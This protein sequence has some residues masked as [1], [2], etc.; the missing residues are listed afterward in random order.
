MG[1]NCPSNQSQTLFC[2]IASFG[3]APTALTPIHVGYQ[4]LQR[5]H[6]LSY[7]RCSLNF[8]NA[9]IRNADVWESQ[10]R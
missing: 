9:F 4:R 1:G 3:Q 5:S 7:W 2:S 6:A 10:Q 8:Q